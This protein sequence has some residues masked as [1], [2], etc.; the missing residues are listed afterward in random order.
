MW[1]NYGNTVSSVRNIEEGI[2]RL[3]KLK[4]VYNDAYLE[5][6]GKRLYAPTSGFGT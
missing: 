4:E 6:E 3:L 2:E 1:L 5:F